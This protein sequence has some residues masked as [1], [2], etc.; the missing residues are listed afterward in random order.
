MDRA[1]EQELGLKVEAAR[2]PIKVLI[3][4]RIEKPSEN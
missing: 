1:L 4:D 3:I 2:G